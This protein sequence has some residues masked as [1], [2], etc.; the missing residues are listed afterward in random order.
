MIRIL[1]ESLV[2]KIAAGEVIVRPAS[3]VKELVENAIDAKA[4]RI[5]IDLANACRNIRV[6]DDGCGIPREDLPAALLRHATSKIEK[7]ED[8]WQ[9]ETRGFRGEALASI[10][11]VAKLTIVSRARG[12]IAGA[13]LESE[14]GS[15]PVV[16]AAG[17]PEGTEVCVRDLFFNIPVRLKFLKSPAS[18]LQ[19]ILY[20]VTRQALIRPDIGFVVTNEKQTLLDVPPQ[21]PW[22]E[23]VIALLGLEAANH[24]LEVETARHIV[25]VRGF[26]ATPGFTRKDRRYQF[27][28]I[29]GR[30]I[31]SRS[32]SNVVQ[33]AYKGLLM[34]QR[35]AVVVLNVELPAREVDVNVHP[36]KEE[37]RLRDEPMVL[38]VVHRAVQER[39]AAA[40]LIPSLSLP[41]EGKALGFGTQREFLSPSEWHRQ[42]SATRLPGD[43][44]PF[45]MPSTSPAGRV[46]TE[47]QHHVTAQ[48]EMRTLL[49]AAS[50]I[51]GGQP[52][53][54]PP[55]Q[56]DV[57]P[58]EQHA[59]Q[60]PIPDSGATELL[61]AGGTYP[62]PLGQIG[63]C[64]IVA[65]AGDNLL[66]IDQHAAHERLL[67]MKFREA[68]GREKATQPLLIPVTVDVPPAI[69][70]TLR[71]LLPVCETLG[72]RV[73][74]FG[75]NTF[76]VQ[77]VPA[78]VPHLD[79][80]AVLA[81]L[82]DDVEECAGEALTLDQLRDRIITRMAC[83]AAIKAGQQLQIE[84]M[85]EL[86]RDIVD[87]HLGFT[88]PHGRPTMII[89]TRAQL[90][91]QFKRVV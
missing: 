67:Y 64:Y 63:D 68:L 46:F 20:M 82:A 11:A 85:R 19:F 72:M 14:P 36:T 41:A 91:R 2:N 21:Q 76:V 77:S 87:S 54:M 25:S 15:E 1:P 5:I 60:P 28:F 31:T 56:C 66:L 17:A 83:R 9:L 10:A 61:L 27:F 12:E 53:P 26:V 78:D 38:G 47:I 89:L 18:E 4:T 57:H 24:L 7:F 23:R 3:V 71:E 29:N 16:E 59:Q 75:G 42:Q 51:A 48:Q 13:R 74:H 69:I 90:D 65:R 86:I 81:D 6:R 33:Q 43:F 34:T 80:G 30:P 70:P 39:L 8:L 62:E 49:E 50:G 58:F 55:A 40:N 79:A 35:F 73:E 88:C 22:R 45:T 52:G 37:V 84:E 32:L 44:T